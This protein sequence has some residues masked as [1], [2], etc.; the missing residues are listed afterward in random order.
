MGFVDGGHDEVRVHGQAGFL[1]GEG[2][3]AGSGAHESGL[4]LGAAVVD[5]PEEP[6]VC[7]GDAAVEFGSPAGADDEVGEGGHGKPPFCIKMREI[8]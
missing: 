8:V 2:V 7:G 4:L 6:G 1:R 5:G 3:G